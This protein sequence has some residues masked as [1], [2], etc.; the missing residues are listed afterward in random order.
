MA[1]KNNHLEKDLSIVV[2][3]GGKTRKID[4]ARE[5]EVAHDNPTVL[6]EQMSRQPA[7]FAW[8]GVLEALATKQYEEAKRKQKEIYAVVDRERRKHREDKGLKVTEALISADVERDDRYIAASQ[9]IV[10]TRYAR[11]ILAAAVGG[12]DHRKDML[13]NIG[14]QLRSERGSIRTMSESAKEKIRKS[15]DKQ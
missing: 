4:L 11:D 3:L 12:F 6:T 14:S 1:K 8:M 15:R 10:E 5:L 9:E 13:V 7:M 2:K